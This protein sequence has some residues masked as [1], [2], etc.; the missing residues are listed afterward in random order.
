MATTA[1]RRAAL[2]RAMVLAWVMV[3]AWPP[4]G[5]AENID[6][7][8]S[9]IA[10]ASRALAAG[11]LETAGKHY[12]RA[13][14][15]RPDSAVAWLGLARVRES[16]GKLTEALALAR[17]AQALAPDEAAVAIVVG[18]LLTRLGAVQPALETLARA[19]RLDPGNARSYLLAALLLRD[20]DRAGEAVEL[21][22]KARAGGLEAPE[23]S[24][25][26]GLLLLT[27]DRPE[28][29]REVAE[30]ALLRH[31]RRAGLLLVHGLA[32]ASGGPELR[33]EAIGRLEESLELDVSKPG[34][35]HLELGVLLAGEGLGEEALG[36]L[37][38]ARRLLPDSAEVQYRLGTALRA[39]GDRE[40]A[41][42]ALER[43]REISRRQ[44]AEDWSA[45]QAGT[46][47]NEAQALATGNRL[48]AALEHLDRLLADHP[49]MARAWTL[50]AKVLFSTGRGREA[51]A[52]IV[53]AREL[54]PGET[55]PHYLEGLFL[56]RLGRPAAAEVALGRALALDAE[57]G[58]AWELLGG[59][60]AKQGRPAEAAEHFRRAL[61]AGTDSPALRLGYA[62]A[63]EELGLEQESEQQK[64]A[65]RRL[66]GGR[67]DRGSQ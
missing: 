52:S 67:N 45:K 5:L 39:A 40:G 56:M 44:D 37:R 54:E 4:A 64:E 42:A 60:A 6:S 49:R 12:S 66:A 22:E 8:A 65:Y 24:E 46:A 61:A 55:E 30:L 29:A 3:L 33:R 36:H 10:E 19:R 63:L 17:R 15:L 25:E 47:L 20:E 43:F 31:P 14:E 50:K 57:L 23:I 18:G 32:L 48:A 28:S 38:E 11:D 7:E 34:R 35:V 51:V 16:R 26:L 53:R 58:A 41:R 62:G 1:I 21:L 59:I 9:L 27:A 2:A 13:R